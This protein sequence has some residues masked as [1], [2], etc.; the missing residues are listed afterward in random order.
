MIDDLHVESNGTAR[1]SYRRPIAWLGWAMAL[2]L[3][4]LADPLDIHPV[5]TWLHHLLGHH[6][7][8]AASA[9]DEH[10]HGLWT[11]PMHPDILAEEPG[12][13]P[14]CGM[15]LVP[16]EAG[17]AAAET[18]SATA[19]EL[20]G[21]HQLWTCG[22]HPQVIQ[23]DPGACPICHMELT[24]LRTQAAAPAG[25]ERSILFYRNP[26]DPTITSPVP[27]KDEM[28]MDYVPVYSDE[29]A[30]TIG[31]GTV[32]TIDPAVEQNMNVATTPAGTR[33]IRRKVRTVG[34]L[35]VD[36]ERIVSVTIKYSGFV[37]KVFVNYVGEPVSTG[38]P[39]FEVYSPELVQTQQELLSALEFAGKLDGAEGD[40]AAR[41][42]ALVAAVRARLA[43]WDIT[44][45]QIAALEQDGAVVRTLR[46][47]APATGVVL[48]RMEGLEGMAVRP[49]MAVMKV[50]DLSFLWLRAE[51]FEDQ[52]ALVNVGGNATINL[53]YFPGES[54]SGAIRFVEPVLSERTRTARVVLS[55]PNP[56]LRLRAGM[57]ATVDLEPKRTRETVTVPSQAVIRTGERNVVVVALGGGRFAPR[58]VTLG[59][60]ADGYVEI[61][62]GLTA[63]EQVVT[64]AQFLID[65][66]SNLQAAIQ[67]LIAA[68]RQGTGGGGNAQ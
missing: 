58:E 10:A 49:G 26:M 3:L 6:E 34:Y 50:A 68:R 32:V 48:E 18:T 12:S 16:V 19:T 39:L 55:V 13:C 63:G 61:R 20:G 62:E 66:E 67:K 56:A 41:A 53:T 35:E 59:V 30:A 42:R 29:T 11:C 52:L 15:D 57:Y 33:D 45:D 65:S 2:L 22:M 23:D 37:E 43:Y 8:H 7:E 5:D 64:S 38:Q 21:E 44:A 1:R 25:G 28:G 46:V 27:A 14:I 60:A 54:F 51:V 40:A 17:V 47:V 36:P 4:L 31:Q 9:G 24:P